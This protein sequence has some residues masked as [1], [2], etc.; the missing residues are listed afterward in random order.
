M[1]LIMNDF[2]PGELIAQRY[3]L[4][5]SLGGGGFGKVWRAQDLRT[6]AQLALKVVARHGAHSP[7]WREAHILRRLN[8]P[9]VVRLF[10]EG[11]LEDYYFLAMELVEGTPF[12]GASARHWESIAEVVMRLAR[13]LQQV[14]AAG[15][16]HRDLKPANVLVT[17]GTEVKL[18]DFGLS[19]DMEMLSALESGHIE[20]SIYYLAP[21]QLR[22]EPTTVRSDIYALGVMLY[23]S[24]SGQLPRS[25]ATMRGML[26]AIFTE[27]VQPLSARVPR[28][29][30][31]LIER[32]IAVDPLARPSSMGEVL[33]V[34]EGNETVSAILSQGPRL[35]VSI[36]RGAIAPLLEALTQRRPF[37]LRLPP[38]KDPRDEDFLAAMLLE[39]GYLPMSL[40]PGARPLESLSGVLPLGDELVS[41]S[42]RLKQLEQM[43]ET[44]MPEQLVL[45]DERVVDAW[46]WKILGAFSQDAPLLRIHRSPHERCV[47]MRVSLETLRELF[48]GPELVMHMPSEGAR[49][50][51]E[52]TGGEV[53]A[54][55]REVE[56]WV[57][58][59]HARWSGRP[60]R[61]SMTRESVI[62]LDQGERPVVGSVCAE[63]GGLSARAREVLVWMGLS[64]PRNSAPMVA[65]LMRAPCWEVE[66]LMESLRAHGLLHESARETGAG[67]AC[68]GVMPLEIWTQEQLTEA[69]ARVARALGVGSF[70]RGRHELAAGAL[71]G[72]LESLAHACSMEHLI[73]SPREAM[74]WLEDALSLA[75]RR[76]ERAA[77]R[78]LLEHLARVA[79]WGQASQHLERVLSHLEREQRERPCEWV[80]AL[81]TLVSCARARS[82][83]LGDEPQWSAEVEVLGAFEDPDLEAHRQ[84][85][86]LEGARHQEALG[87]FEARP[88]A[89]FMGLKERELARQLSAREQWHRAATS[90]ALARQSWPQNVMHVLLC[91][92]GEALARIACGEISRASSL[93]AYIQPGSYPGPRARHL[94]LATRLHVA[95]AAGTSPPP[96]SPCD[97]AQV[98][99]LLDVPARENL[100]QLLTP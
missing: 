43:F 19:H 32:M 31:A 66:L 44:L 97:Y 59:G 68:A 46:T 92:H 3:Q 37:D 13:A 16:L 60:S 81:T 14:H 70:E 69:H 72:T 28:K 34:V 41:L 38:F 39:Q 48:H 36:W 90:Y 10:D 89:R 93:L 67:W 17:R 42:E 29:I 57:T 51:M 21:E 76:D 4:L 86:W 8:L 94:A 12:P 35:P 83:G 74:I 82:H 49:L 88:E 77:R 84:I 100:S 40:P 54:L 91:L 52:R 26:R 56:A 23:E 80:S 61:L 71:E 99:S 87:W 65:R 20:G 18:L 22:G 53:F 98:L 25:G 1:H 50:L 95:R 55:Q 64:W 45:V 2:L 73:S 47:A 62:R 6:Q 27:P 33:A 63:E 9:N 24:L 75:R 85:Y 7:A 78:T 79:L 15:V 96:I 11:P 58:S 5:E 30:A